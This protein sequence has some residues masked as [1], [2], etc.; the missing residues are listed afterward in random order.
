MRDTLRDILVCLRAGI[1]VSLETVEE[2]MSRLLGISML[3][4]GAS[5]VAFASS[6]QAPELDG[7]TAM[8]G[9]ALLAGSVVILRAR[10]RRK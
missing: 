8:S 5:A 2:T 9:L 3:V 6:V 7:G 4:I 10:F 1:T